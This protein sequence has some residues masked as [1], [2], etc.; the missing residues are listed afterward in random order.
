MSSHA[1]SYFSGVVSLLKPIIIFA[2]SSSISSF[3]L[4]FLPDANQSFSVVWQ[5]GSPE[6]RYLILFV[7]LLIFR[8]DGTRNTFFARKLT[9]HMY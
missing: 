1:F 9:D 2:L 8:F 4:F 3:S 5:T 7:L 6:L